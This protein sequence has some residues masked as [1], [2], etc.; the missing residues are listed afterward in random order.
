MNIR[1]LAKEAGVS[2]ATISR[3][4]NHPEAVLSETRDRVQAIIEKYNYDPKPVNRGRRSITLIVPSALR[5]Q[6]LLAGVQ[7]VLAPK[8]ILVNLVESAPVPGGTTACIQAA[9]AAKPIG[10]LVAGEPDLPPEALPADLPVV[11][12]GSYDRLES[13]NICGI[14]YRDAAEKMLSH[15]YAMGHRSIWLL[16]S[17][18]SYPEKAAI[19]AGFQQAAAALGL[20]PRQ[21][22]V[23]E[24]EDS[25]AGGY[26]ICREDI[27]TEDPPQAVF[28]ASDALAMGVIKAARE[29]NIS[30]P[31]GLAVAGF[32]GSEAAAVVVP[33]LTT[34]EHPLERLG[35]V[36]A[37]RLIELIE[38]SALYQVET[39]EIVLK[40]KLK[41]RRS[42]G[43][44]K[45]IYELFE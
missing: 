25:V 34:M 40:S 21:C 3:V 24:S 30:L 35:A 6:P 16:Q 10:L 41:I 27:L 13:C 7:S 44:R 18:R 43:N 15:L 37:R 45:E 14:N 17:S 1:E 2:V 33:A 39:H 19:T 22:R 11:L 42:C 8:G 29:E 36:A 20:T 4:I 23:L 38:D 26:R 31:E 28:A 12:I 32:T 5:T 9:A